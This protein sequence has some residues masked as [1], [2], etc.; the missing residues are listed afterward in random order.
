MRT[1]LFKYTKLVLF[2]LNVP[3]EEKEGLTKLFDGTA[4]GQNVCRQNVHL[5]LFDGRHRFAARKK[6]NEL[7]ESYLGHFVS[8]FSHCY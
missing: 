3:G 2:T 5:H 8:L 4:H 7:H 6:L 1:R